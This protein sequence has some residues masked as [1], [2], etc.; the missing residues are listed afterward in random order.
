MKSLGAVSMHR[1]QAV[2]VLETYFIK[3]QLR[4]G[5]L[6]YVDDIL[7]KKLLSTVTF[8]RI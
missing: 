1:S 2:V 4:S 8:I 5:L 6:L 3:Q 7:P